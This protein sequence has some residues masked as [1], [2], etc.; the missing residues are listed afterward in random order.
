MISG[1]GGSSRSDGNLASHHLSG[2]GLPVPFNIPLVLH[3]L[4]FEEIGIEFDSRQLD[5][6]ETLR[7]SS[8][9]LS[10]MNEKYGPRAQELKSKLFSDPDNRVLIEEQEQLQL[11]FFEAHQHFKELVIVL[12]DILSREQYG[13]LLEYSN[14]PT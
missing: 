13:K 12:A 9:A 14:I 2:G 5:M 6:L 4:L 3:N 7:F 10:R 8:Y 11:D 1:F